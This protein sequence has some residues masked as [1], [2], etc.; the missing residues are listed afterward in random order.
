MRP[1]AWRYSAALTAVS[2]N[3]RVY[4]SRFQLAKV[5][6][7]RCPERARRGLSGKPNAAELVLE[8]LMDVAAGPLGLAEHF[9]PVC[10]GLCGRA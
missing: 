6:V 9:G 8:L 1:I 2:I 3:A 7:E 5:V 10:G 4:G